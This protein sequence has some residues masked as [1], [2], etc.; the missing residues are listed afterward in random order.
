MKILIACEFSGR[1]RDAFTKA[2]H[3]A[4][5]CDILP[6][7]IPGNHIQGDVSAIV[8][9]GWDMMI[10]HPPCTYLANSGVQYLH[11]RPERIEQMIQA[12]KFFMMLLNAPIPMI[13]VENPVPHSY[14]RLPRYD[15]IIEPYYFGDEATKRTCL[16][17]KGLPKLIADNI[18]GRGDRYIQKDG[19]SNGSAWYQ[20]APLTDRAKIRSTTFLGIARA[21]AN[22]WRGEIVPVQLPLFQ[23]SVYD[24]P[25]K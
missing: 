20:L 13:A 4:W 16:W 2:G 15:Q 14:A 24:N 18:V 6:T 10:A 3:D 8:H 21:M 25:M 11:Q 22:Q 19:K 9:D 23:M 17:L 12:R 5:S 1:V 7:E